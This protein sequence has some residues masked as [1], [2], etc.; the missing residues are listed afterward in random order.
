M[1]DYILDLDHLGKLLTGALRKMG[2]LSAAEITAMLSSNQL[3]DLILEA[4]GV[5]RDKLSVAEQR[6]FSALL[7]EILAALHLEKNS[8]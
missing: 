2:P 6:R 7:L 3:E 8:H 1:E 5:S 4:I